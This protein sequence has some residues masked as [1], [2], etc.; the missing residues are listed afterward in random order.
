MLSI[1]KITA[2]T[3]NLDEIQA[4]YERAFPENERRPFMGMLNSQNRS[5]EVLAL[6]DG[7]L[8]CG[9]AILLN[10]L[11]ISHIIYLAIEE[12]LRN[13][14]YGSMALDVLQK[15]KSGKRIIVDIEMEVPGADNNEQRRR[16]K[17]FYIR[18]G[19][20]QTVIRY[21]WQEEDYE[22]MSH[23]GIV[24]EEDYKAFWHQL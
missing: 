20:V 9:F 12:N 5:T 14:G 23:G 1:R 4:L 8:F 13:R 15:H 22:I 19:Y 10:G 18:N 17:E 24:S 3:E 6:Y 21:R 7:E 2:D 11:E 16:R